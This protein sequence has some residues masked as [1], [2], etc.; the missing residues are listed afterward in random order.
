GNEVIQTTGYQELIDD[1]NTL[2][3]SYN[4]L[5]VEA[6]NTEAILAN[7]MNGMATITEESTNRQIIAFEDLEQAQQD[8]ITNLQ[9]YYTGLKDHTTDMFNEIDDTIMTT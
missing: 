2:K 8:T 4:D 5:T 1:T 9:D 7:S 6:Q 3:Q